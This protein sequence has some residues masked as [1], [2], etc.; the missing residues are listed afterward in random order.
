VPLRP[1]AL[2]LILAL[3]A[4]APKPYVCHG[5]HGGYYLTDEASY[6]A[7]LD[8]L[9]ALLEKAPGRKAA[10]ELEPYTLERMREG[11]AFGVE[12]RGREVPRVPFW[13]AG[14]VGKAK[15]EYLPAAAHTGQRGARVRLVQG[16][17]AHV[18]Q[19][20]AATDLGGVRLR[21][22]AWIRN[23]KGDAHLYLD[24]HDSAGF[25]AG[26]AAMTEPVPADG[27]WH[28]VGFAYL[29][30]VGAVTIYPQGKVTTP[31]GEADFDDFT[32]QRL[33]T[34]EELL[35]NGGFEQMGPPSLKDR[36][37][38]GRLRELVQR[39]RLEIVGG[40]YTQPIMYLL[41]G[42]SVVQQLILGCRAVEEALSR[43][44]RVYAA[45]EPGWVGQLPQLL[46]QMGFRGCV[47]RTNWQ[48]FGAAPA[49]NAEV[50]E[51]EG[52]EGSS[53]PAIPMPAALRAG[54]G[55]HAPTPA[56][57]AELAAAGLR[58]PFFLD[59]GDFVADWVLRPDDPR[60]RGRFYSG[61]VH[62]CRSIAAHKAAGREIELRAWLRARQP[63]A[64]LYV[65]AYH[66]G[67][68]LA[69]AESPCVPADGQWHGLRLRW[70]V[71]AEA[72]L[73]YP[74][75]R[76]YA[77]AERGEVDID[78][79]SLKV[80]ESGEELLPEGS[81]E[82][83]QLPAGWGAGGFAGAKAQAEVRAG[84][85]PTGRG[86]V[87]LQMTAAALDA[88]LVT[89][90]EYLDLMGPPPQ[91]WQDAYAGFEH[92]YPYGILGGYHL[93][94]DRMGERSLLAALRLDA[95]LGLGME[96]WRADFWRLL[97][98][99]QH[100][101]AWVCAP[102]RGFGI[103]Q[104]YGRYADLTV[105]CQEELAQRLR[106]FAP[107]PPAGEVGGV[108]NLAA[109]RQKAVCRL[110]WELPPGKCRRP[111]V[112]NAAGQ[113]APA[114]VRV[115]QRHPE[116]SV[117]RAEATLLADLPALGFCRY[118]MV[119]AGDKRQPP[120]AAV[121]VTRG[122]E[123][124]RV[125]NSSVA[126]EIGRAGVQIYRGGEP[127]LRAPAHLAGY[128]PEG[129][130]QS[131]FE[132]FSVTEAPGEAT[133][134]AEGRVGP[135]KLHLRLRLGAYAACALAEVEADFG[136]RTLVGAGPEEPPLRAGWS[137]EERKL[138]WVLP[139][140]WSAPKFLAAGAFE[141]RAPSRLW[142]PVVGLALAQGPEG[143]LAVYP[144]RAT[145]GIFSPNPPSLEIV[146]AYGGPFIYAPE[147]LCPLQGKETYCLG[148]YPYTGTPE[149]AR[150][151]QREEVA[152]PSALAAPIA[153]RKVPRAAGQLVEIRPESAVAVSNCYKDGPDLV[154]RFWR[155]YEGVAQVGI[156]VWGAKELWLANLAGIPQRKLA[157]GPRA[158][159]SV[160]G[161]QI[162]TLRAKGVWLG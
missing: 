70:R 74:Q 7:A 88:A 160:R 30:P 76:I 33:D 143:G 148:L 131:T 5:W 28:Q 150:V 21:F 90:S 38:L 87:R 126:F 93:R 129:P 122:R 68:Y 61:L 92:R 109:L 18:C 141:L 118:R 58:R 14:G 78:V 97:L 23:R 22:S 127:M 67:R 138:A 13:G 159:L 81:F 115:Q 37:R 75:V 112:V 139:L 17:Y 55:L 89:P 40:A 102:V 153:V 20:R 114:V 135:V 43:P 84:E 79:L 137:I 123:A 46:A 64:H 24:A 62:L 95:L 10:L 94:A 132:D 39:G 145:A 157:G 42:E 117:A 50:V 104:A 31:G 47:Y 134:I 51:W 49:R 35:G 32:L 56:L 111:L 152:V 162:V 57:V 12:R 128:F 121:R 140:K 106:Q 83:G 125:E 29:V 130:Q 86:Y 116:G 27:Q 72:D 71:P 44:V 161:Q 8:K 11:E 110:A 63:G 15:V 52:P 77:R 65:D 101:D 158:K 54:W 45:Q 156:V 136:E 36:Q 100:H 147:Q 120:L 48:A 154:L 103:W 59:L 85:A 73:L 144:D 60:A 1:Q 119:E 155:P 26:S 99:G 98:M 16:T 6:Q 34:G 82:A 91:Q 41:G 19:G 105:A 69:G 66:A 151:V 2:G 80:V 96:K 108:Y 146:L 113:P 3:L 4:Q 124:V 25:I 107:R 142:W 149:T 53:L 9:F 133:A